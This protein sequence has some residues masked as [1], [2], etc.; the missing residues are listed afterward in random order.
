MDDIMI[1]TSKFGI[2]IC[3]QLEL[4]KDAWLANVVSR[5]IRRTRFADRIAL[6]NRKR[7]I[8]DDIT[9]SDI[10]PVEQAHYHI[11]RMGRRSEYPRDGRIN[12]GA[13]GALV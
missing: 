8:L 9:P 12:R 2:Y 7:I 6:T 1:N 13:A 11:G 10:A 5:V 3:I 4:F